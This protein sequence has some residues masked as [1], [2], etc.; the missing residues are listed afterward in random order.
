MKTCTAPP[1]RPAT[2]SAWAAASTSSTPP[3][4]WG[5]NKVEGHD[6]EHA[7]LLE[8]ALRKS[9]LVAYVRYEWEQ[10]SGE[11]LHLNEAEYGHDALFPV[12]AVTL[13]AGYDVL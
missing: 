11:E 12:D 6:G 2:A 1:R 13:G 4:P 10:K 9:R 3:G 7:A 8:A 5:L